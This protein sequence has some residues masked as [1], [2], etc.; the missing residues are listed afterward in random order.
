MLSMNIIYLDTLFFINCV[1]DYFSLLCA[2]KISGASLNRIRFG[3]AACVGGFYACGCV[4]PNLLWFTHPAI[5]LV[6]AILL[7]LIAFGKE[8]HFFR[9][10]ITFLT[11]SAAFGGIFTAL[12]W[13]DGR[14]LFFPIDL[15][16]LML[17][18]A[19]AYFAISTLFRQYGRVQCREFHAASVTFNSRTVQF[20][21]LKDTGNELYDPISNTAVLICEHRAMAPLFP[22]IDLS[23]CQADP[24]TLFDNISSSNTTQGKMRLVPFQT[25]G[26]N[27]LLIGFKPDMIKIDN[28][29]KQLIVAM[30][31]KT[32]SLN[33]TYQGIY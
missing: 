9:C 31:D 26:G 7:C 1:T 32:F 4:I 23:G 16:V 5:K 20:T 22:D 29:P 27:G 17:T 19:A 15:K 33:N 28:Q 12:S 24:Y 30:T 25:V 11:V 2:G 10:C 8:E 21:V 14:L 3:I 18:F 13:S 6:C